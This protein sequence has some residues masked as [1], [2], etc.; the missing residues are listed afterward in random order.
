ML[1]SITASIAEVEEEDTLKGVREALQSDVAPLAL[2]E[3]LVFTLMPTQAYLYTMFALAVM[4]V[5]LV[6]KPA[7]LFGTLFEEERL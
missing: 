3:A 4:V 7:G 2:V 6:V 5:M 1:E